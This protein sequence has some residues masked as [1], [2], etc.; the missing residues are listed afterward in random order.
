MMNRVHIFH[1]KI[2]KPLSSRRGVALLMALFVIVTLTALVVSFLSTTQRHLHLTRHYKNG[3]QAYWSAQSGLQAA[4]AGLQVAALQKQQVPNAGG[5]DGYN[6]CWNAESTCYQEAALAL[7]SVPLCGDSYPQAALLP[8]M[9]D[10]LAVEQP[11][12][13]PALIVDENRKLSVRDLVTSWGQQTEKTKE[14]VFLRLK[15]LLMVVLKETDLLSPEDRIQES[16]TNL[17]SGSGVFQ[18]ISEDQ[19]RTL[20][21]YVVDWIDTFNNSADTRYNSDLA[22]E[23]CPEDGLPYAAK[24]GQLDSTEEIALVCGFR[25][26]QRQVIEELTRSLTVYNITNTNINTATQPVL[27]AFVAAQQESPTED[28][29]AQIYDLLHPTDEMAL[30]ED[31]VVQNMG[32]L[33]SFLQQHNI[34]LDTNLTT[35]LKNNMGVASTIFRVGVNGVVIDPETGGVE[36]NSR[37]TMVISF[38][39]GQTPAQQQGAGLLYYREG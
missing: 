37:V 26:M 31:H 28:Y 12:R 3:T 38:G 25:Q 34:G 4:V 22:E 11:E 8:A 7:L 27:H 29:S 18:P 1:E 13:T 20:A 9:R 14:D 17:S 5:Y 35:Y 19:A 30:P 23:T 36:A 21:G 15:Y 10:P 24:N 32:V 6:S 33:E 39:Q 2:K 16:G